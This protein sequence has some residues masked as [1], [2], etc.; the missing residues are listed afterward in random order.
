M[1][2]KHNRLQVKYTR[3]MEYR[4][5]TSTPRPRR[6]FLFLVSSCIFLAGILIPLGLTVFT[7]SPS[8]RAGTFWTGILVCTQVQQFNYIINDNDDIVDDSL[9][10]RC[11]LMEYTTLHGFVFGCLVTAKDT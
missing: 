9:Y 4:E 6:I 8:Y 3:S 11:L 2:R 1:T 7:F 5:S 10:Y